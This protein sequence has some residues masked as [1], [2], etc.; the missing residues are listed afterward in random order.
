MFFFVLFFL[1]FILCA[2]NKDATFLGCTIFDVY[3][4]F[5]MY[6]RSLMH[7]KAGNNLWDKFSS[8]HKC[9]CLNVH[10]KLLK[11]SLFARI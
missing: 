9:E 2:M 1:A 11:C 7:I 8:L 4:S 5:K 6:L 10:S 3:A